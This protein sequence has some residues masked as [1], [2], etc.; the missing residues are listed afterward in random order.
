MAFKVNHLDFNARL[1]YLM[2]LRCGKTCF[3]SLLKT[4]KLFFFKSSMCLSDAGV[5]LL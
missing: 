1:K 3:K 4:L 2:S 5:K